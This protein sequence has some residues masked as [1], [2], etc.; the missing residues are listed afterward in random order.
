LV[1]EFGDRRVEIRM[2]HTPNLTGIRKAVVP[3]R[4]N[5]GWG[6]QHMKL[7]GIDDEVILSGANLS[8]DY[9]TNRQDRYHVFS[10]PHLAEYFARI[11][12]AVCKLSFAVLPPTKKED[13]AAGYAMLWPATN[14]SPSPLDDP[15]AFRRHATTM[16]GSL[17]HLT[18]LAPKAEPKP[19]LRTILSLLSSPAWSGSKWTFTAGYFNMTPEFR[20]LLLR[21]AMNLSNGTIITASP[22]ANGFYKSSGVSGMLPDGYTY[23]SKKFLAAVGRRGLDDFISLKEWRRGTVNE[24]DGWSYHAKGIWVTL[25]EEQDVGPS[26]SIVGSS[27]YTKRAYGLD[28]ESNVAIVTRDEDLMGRLKEEEEWLQDYAKPMTRKDYE[29]PE[30]K[31]RWQVRAAIWIVTLLGGAL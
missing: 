5:E 15:K 26:I 28:L 14:P 9:F 11:H 2:F 8:S 16:L 31:V 1:E 30:R 24:G 20:R 7:Y 18:T 22:W 21:S 4:I 29:E 6:L 10:C 25:P 27:N 3:R 12:H 19:A 17:M 23:L 13:A